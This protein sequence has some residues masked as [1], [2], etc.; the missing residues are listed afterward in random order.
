[1]TGGG[2]CGEEEEEDVEH[3]REGGSPMR[4]WQSLTERGDELIGGQTSLTHHP[5]QRT[6]LDL[7]MNRDDASRRPS[8]QHD[9]AAAL[10]ELNEAEPFQRS[11]DLRPGEYRIIRHAR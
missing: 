10:P 1:M 7:A 4:R 9:V 8:P 11:H 3:G 5:T 6:P 2:R